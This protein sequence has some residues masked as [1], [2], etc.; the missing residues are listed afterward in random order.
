M[1]PPPPQTQSPRPLVVLVFGGTGRVG[2]EVLT[3]AL[4]AGHEVRAFV[5]SPA[6]LAL[7]DVRMR[8]LVGD[9][10]RDTD[11]VRAAVADGVDAVV[12]AIGGDVFRPSTLVT[13]AAR[14]L[15]AACA[16]APRGAPRYVAV[17]GTAEMPRKSCLGALTSAGLRASPIRHAV[18]D[19]D[20]AFAAVMAAAA[21]AP[22]VRYSIVACPYIA[23]G[24]RTGAYSEH[25][26]F[27]GGF[28]TIH[29]GDVA[30]CLLRHVGDAAGANRIV[31]IW[32]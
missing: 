22:P 5:R 11:A 16:R 9:V 19:H 30:E 10:L 20:G 29:P 3:Q 6:K 25:D 23:D 28:L 26:V 12:N 1:R 18:R 4:A 21:A 13:D 7:R 27:E 8:V 2:L 32:Y 17:T 15:L 14:A 31:G 24:P